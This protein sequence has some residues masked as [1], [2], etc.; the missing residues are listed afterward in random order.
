[1]NS[2]AMT[3]H[4]SILSEVEVFMMD[5]S[6]ELMSIDVDIIH[7]YSWCKNRS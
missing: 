5:K 7:R 2:C 4:E 3:H 1:M 6:V